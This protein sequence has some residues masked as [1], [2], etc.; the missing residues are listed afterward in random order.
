MK[1]NKALDLASSALNQLLMYGTDMAL[2]QHV[3]QNLFAASF[4]LTLICYEKN[5]ILWLKKYD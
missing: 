5:I 2:W 1:L 3:T 4:L